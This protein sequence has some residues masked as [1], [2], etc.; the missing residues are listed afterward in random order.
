MWGLGY[1]VVS[2][3]LTPTVAPPVFTFVPSE[4]TYETFSF[5]AQDEIE[6][7]DDELYFTLGA[8]LQR[9]DFTGF[10]VQPS[11]RLLW[12]PEQS[13]AAWAAV[14]RAVRTPARTDHDLTFTPPFAAVVADFT[15]AF[16]SEEVIAYELG[17]R[18][19]P[20]ESFSWDI[21]LFYNQYQK[22]QSFH[23]FPPP[24]PPP[25]V[26]TLNVD[27]GAGYGIELSAKVAM[28]P[29]WRISGTYSLL[30]VNYEPGAGSLRFA[31]EPEGTSPQ[32]QVFL[33]SSHDLSDN[34]EFDLMARYVDS[35]PFQ[36]VP[37]YISLDA[38]LAWRPTCGMEFAVVGQNLLD[39]QHPEYNQFSTDT[40]KGQPFE[41]QRGVYGQ[42]TYQW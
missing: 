13:W 14:S 24:P 29:C 21:A 36:A 20:V 10:E 26:T 11:A 30:K 9:N 19:Q 41:I 23:V 5:F 8:K 18:A 3:K 2:D 37:S 7:R 28:T 38:R 17:Y 6:L 32:H 1:R 35:L 4:R 42:V 34:V 39:S 40:T 15:E 31:E 33:M 27:R 22:L 25:R 12:A 16:Q